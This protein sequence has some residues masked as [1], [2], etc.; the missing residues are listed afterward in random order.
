M[1]ETYPGYDFF[2]EFES[3]GIF[4]EI[5]QKKED[6]GDKRYAVYFYYQNEKYAVAGNDMNLIKEIAIEYE[7]VVANSFSE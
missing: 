6:S 4:F 1:R 2:E 5:F 7:T 3:N